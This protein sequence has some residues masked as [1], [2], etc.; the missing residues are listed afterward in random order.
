MAS[1]FFRFAPLGGLYHHRK[2]P[3]SSLLTVRLVLAYWTSGSEWQPQPSASR[4]MGKLMPCS[5]CFIKKSV[6][7]TLQCVTFVTLWPEPTPCDQNAPYVRESRLQM[8]CSIFFA[9]DF[10][11]RRQSPEHLEPRLPFECNKT[12]FRSPIHT[13]QESLK[14]DGYRDYPYTSISAPFQLTNERK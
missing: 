13:P 4:N 2:I 11:L 1:P 12:V 8:F 3:G 14:G 9:S 7:L 5:S 6:S 10:S